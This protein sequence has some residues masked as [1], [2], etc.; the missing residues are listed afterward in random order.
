MSDAV[1]EMELSEFERLEFNRRR[2]VAYAVI[3]AAIRL[4]SERTKLEERIN[5]TSKTARS[6]WYWVVIAGGVVLNYFMSDDI[7]RF[8]WGTGIA[9]IAIFMWYSKQYQLEQLKSQRDKYNGRL[10]ELE[11]VWNGATGS[12][13]TFWDINRFAG[14]F[15]FDSEENVF[16][17]WWAKQTASILARVCE[18][19]R[20]GHMDENLEKRQARLRDDI[21]YSRTNQ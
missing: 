9:L 8:T 21:R 17:D 10:Y 16:C 18:L 1:Q 4:F 5:S 20:G 15:G 14:E 3:P 19:Q 13:I 11:V 6:Y 12:S 2:D 7:H